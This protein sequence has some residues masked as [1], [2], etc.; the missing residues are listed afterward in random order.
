MGGEDVSANGLDIVEFGN[1]KG[2]PNRVCFREK[3]PARAWLC[4]AAMR[5]LIGN[6]ALFVGCD[7]NAPL[8]NDEWVFGAVLHTG[9]QG[10]G[11]DEDFPDV[12]S[13]SEAMD[14]GAVDTWEIGGNHGGFQLIYVRWLWGERLIHSVVW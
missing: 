3:G 5:C 12:E 10:A 8:G 13:G 7:F 6:A 9:K 2:R 4:N 14:N 11:G 1:V